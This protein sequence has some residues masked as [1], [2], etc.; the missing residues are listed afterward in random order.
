[1]TQNYFVARLVIGT[2]TWT[3]AAFVVIGVAL[4]PSG[5]LGL[6]KSLPMG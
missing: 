4:F 2:V 1:M 5:I 3:E 6:G